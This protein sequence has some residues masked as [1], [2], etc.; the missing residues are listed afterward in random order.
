MAGDALAAVV[1]L[2]AS[3]SALAA[4]EPVDFV[5]FDQ[6]TVVNEAD[7][8]HA[9]GGLLGADGTNLCATKPESIVF[10]N[11]TYPCFIG[12]EATPGAR[13]P[14]NM[15]TLIPFDQATV[16]DPTAVTIVPGRV[17]TAEGIDLCAE[18]PGSIVFPDGRYPCF[19]N[20]VQIFGP[21]QFGIFPGPQIEQVP[22]GGADTGVPASGTDPAIGSGLGVLGA[23]VLAAGAVVGLL[24]RRR[25][26]GQA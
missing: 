24:A 2:G 25:H 23:A 21:Q 9:D 20:Y 4:P 16:V 11:G 17:I 19:I 12:W 15:P 7:V 10:P 1:L 5:P 18:N 26:D 6:A 22:V 8:I 13:F 3:T 14:I